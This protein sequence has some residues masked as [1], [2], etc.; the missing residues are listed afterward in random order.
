M[1]P[2]WIILSGILLSTCVHRKNASSEM[3]PIPHAQL[4]ADISSIRN[5][6]DP[7]IKSVLVKGDQM[8]ILIQFNGGCEHHLFQL[9]GAITVEE[10]APPI[11]K[12]KLAHDNKNDSCRELVEQILVFDIRPLGIANE[13]VILKLDG[14]DGPLNYRLSK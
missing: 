14:F 9:M 7:I 2:I 11:R 1:R 10:G 12:L 13:E 8:T 4:T 6:S 5:T 3:E